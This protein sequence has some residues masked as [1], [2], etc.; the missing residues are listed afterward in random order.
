MNKKTRFAAAALAGSVF[1]TLGSGIAAADPQGSPTYRQL[2]G[3]GSDTTQDVMNGMANAVTISG[4]K[5]IGS[6][7]ATGSAQITTKDPAVTPGCTINRPF[8]STAGRTALLT[9]LQANG[10]AGDGC[11]D[12]A[13]S[14]SSKGS[15]TST[16]SMTWVPFAIEAISYGVTNTSVISRN[17]TLDDLKNYYKCDPGYVGTG[18]NWDVTPILP[19]SGSG[20]RSYWIGQMGITE[21]Q[22]SGGQYPCLINGVKNGQL[23]EEHT[24]TVLDDK[25]IVPFSIAQYN[26]QST[27]LIPD[28]RGRAVLGV[29]N[30]TVPNIANTGFSVKRDLF[31]IIPT[32]KIGTAPWSTVFVGSGSLVCQQTAVLGL[33]GV[34]TNPNCGDTS[35]QS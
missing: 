1:A 14:S 15:F 29:V 6:Y 12:F 18:P 22:I 33:Y 19:Q 27:Q 5:V 2:A 31:N 21:A 34:A 20:T 3:A 32:A 7:D 16:P 24:G 25:S 4:T 13:R 35:S 26:I 10:G 30:G 11:L 28:K 23:I 8:G 17:L 9:S